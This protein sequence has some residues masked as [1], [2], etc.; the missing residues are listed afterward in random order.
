M[1]DRPE[2]PIF[3]QGFAWHH[4]LKGHLEKGI[5]VLTDA[6]FEGRAESS[7]AEDLI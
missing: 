1:D 5:K 6:P 3:V 2:M 7:S 4:R